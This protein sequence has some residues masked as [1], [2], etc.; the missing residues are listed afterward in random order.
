MQGLNSTILYATSLEGVY[1]SGDFGKFVKSK[2]K[3]KV[4]FA[5]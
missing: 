3:Q 1:K 5:A 4:T 2:H